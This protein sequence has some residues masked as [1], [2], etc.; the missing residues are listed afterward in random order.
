MNQKTAK[1]IAH[2]QHFNPEKWDSQKPWKCDS[3]GRE[4]DV[5]H[6]LTHTCYSQPESE[7]THQNGLIKYRYEGISKIEIGNNGGSPEPEGEWAEF[8]KNVHFDPAELGS[9]WDSDDI[10]SYISTHYVSK[11]RIGEVIEGKRIWQVLLPKAWKKQNPD[12]DWSKMIRE[13]KIKDD[14]LSDIKQE[15]LG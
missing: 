3:C 2:D 4:I 12:G 11:K 7:Y 6:N 10:K 9:N 5:S 15:L 8:D 13:E 1:Q 14:V